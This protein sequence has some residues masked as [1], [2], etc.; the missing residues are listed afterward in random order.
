MII[1]IVM[2]HD[3]TYWVAEAVQL[4]IV[5]S[6]P[7]ADLAYDNC[8]Q[9]CL[10]Q[11]AFAEAH[12]PEFTKLFRSPAPETMRRLAYADRDQETSCDHEKLSFVR[13]NYHPAAAA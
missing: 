4:G 5:T 7:E 10:S 6:G 1:E 9:C 12:D 11:V 3:G 8:K 2:H 13:C